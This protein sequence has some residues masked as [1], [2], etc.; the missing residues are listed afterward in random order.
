MARELKQTT[1]TEEVPE[2]VLVPVLRRQVPKRAVQDI[3]EITGENEPWKMPLR[4][5]IR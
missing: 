4:W 5:Y 1:K 2:K 3:P